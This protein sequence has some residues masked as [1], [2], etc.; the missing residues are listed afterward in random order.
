MPGGF[1]PAS[2][3][4]MKSSKLQFVAQYC[5]TLMIIQP[6]AH[7][8]STRERVESELKQLKKY[9][10]KQKNA[11]QY[12]QCEETIARFSSEERL[13]ECYHQMSR[14]KNE[15]RN[16]SIMRYAP[17]DKTYARMMFLTLQINLSIGI[18]CIGQGKYYE[19][20]FKSMR[21][22]CSPL[23]FSGRRRIGPKKE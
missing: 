9:W 20:F 14:Q 12:L 5:T 2:I 13:K 7:G 6:V 19:R 4:P 3:L 8:A 18:D 21:F 11:K 17:K 16:K 22:T 23:T 15:G 10:C 1:S